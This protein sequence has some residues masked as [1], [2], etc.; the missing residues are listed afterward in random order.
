MQVAATTLH[1]KGLQLTDPQNP[2]DP[3]AAHDQNLSGASPSQAKSLPGHS[4]AALPSPAANSR[5]PSG[6]G[7][8]SKLAARAAE[9]ALKREDAELDQRAASERRGLPSNVEGFK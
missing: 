5:A 4:P 1:H 2:G 9:L 7:K 8:T 6:F 3:A